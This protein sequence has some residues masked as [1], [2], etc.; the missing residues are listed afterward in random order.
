MARAIELS[1]RGFPAPNPH[2]GCV[3]VKG[4]KIVGEGFHAFAGGPHAE[5]AALDQAANQARDADVYVTLEPCNHHGRT[6]PCSQ[7]LIAAGVR[8]VT[9][10]VTDP[11]PR[12]GGGAATLAEAGV[13]TSHGLLAN[14]AERENYRFLSAM[15]LRRPFFVAKA[16]ASLDGRIALPSGDSQWI[17]GEKARSAAHLLRA[18]SAGIIVGRRTV[19][20]DNPRL[21]A[22]LRGVINQPVR[23]ILDQKGRLTG[24]ELAF[25]DNHLHVVATNSAAKTNQLIIPTDENGFK[26]HELA[27]ELW[28][29]GLTSI[30]IEGGG[31][32]IASFFRSNLVDRVEL[33]LAPK[34]LGDGPSWVGDLGIENLATAPELEIARVRALGTDL[35]VSA[36]VVRKGNGEVG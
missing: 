13:L 18:E 22:R 10:A 8:S 27:L 5:I 29:R 12:A 1:R 35:W 16:G 15:C 26:L 32:T 17:T 3:I 23:I 6:G 33:F 11:N 34:L 30:L 20:C 7:A 36:N 9:Y 25:G 24:E 31:Q 2:V 28:N 21:T 14:E 4:E 19:E